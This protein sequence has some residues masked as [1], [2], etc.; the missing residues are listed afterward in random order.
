M[1]TV[2]YSDARENLKAMIDKVVADHAPITI[3]RQRGEAAVLI[4]AS[5]WAS[6]EET[7]YLLRSPA[8]A[9]RLLESIAELEAGGGEEH[10]LFRS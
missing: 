3:T 10:E 6:I 1:E 7:L 9:S 5:D 4:S 8:N 2:S